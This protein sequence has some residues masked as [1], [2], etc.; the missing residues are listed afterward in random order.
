MAEDDTDHATARGLASSLIALLDDAR[1]RIVT[2]DRSELAAMVT[3]HL[4]CD[5]AEIPNVSTRFEDWEH[6]NL[7]QGVQAYLDAHSPDAMWF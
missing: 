6:V 2:G 5:V 3:E 1:N 7:H 4:G